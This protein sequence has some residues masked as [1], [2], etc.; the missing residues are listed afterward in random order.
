MYCNS[1]AKPIRGDLITS[2]QLCG[3]TSEENPCSYVKEINIYIDSHL[4][5][6]EIK[7]SAQNYLASWIASHQDFFK[8]LD[9]K[10]TGPSN[11]GL[12]WIKRP[13]RRGKNIEVTFQLE[14]MKDGKSISISFYTFSPSTFF[15]TTKVCYTDDQV[16]DCVNNAIMDLLENNVVR[17]LNSK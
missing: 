2:N 10:A 13:D 14:E 7:D 6:K 17:S 8:N 11:Y 16:L 15:L 4:P 12:A 1:F 3:S 5:T 9:I